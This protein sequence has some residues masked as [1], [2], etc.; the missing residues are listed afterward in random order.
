MSTFSTSTIIHA[1][2]AEVWAALADIGN[3]SVWNPGVVASHLSGE[4]ESGLEAARYCDLGGGNYLDECVVAWEPHQAL[5]MRV[6]GTNLPFKTVD[7][8]FT[9]SAAQGGTRVEVSPLYEV[10]YGPLGRALD[11]L[12]LQRAYEKGMVDLLLGLK[13]HVEGGGKG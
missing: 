9:M 11:A 6:T 3:I 7:I 1:P 8:R 10:K 13:E 4:I 12:Y 2:L 5:T